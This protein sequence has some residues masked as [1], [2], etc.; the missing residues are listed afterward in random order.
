MPSRWG[1][2]FRLRISG[3]IKGTPGGML[4]GPE[5][6]FEM[7]EGVIRAMRHVHMSPADAEF[8]GVK[9]RRQ[10]EIEN[11]RRRAASLWTKCWCRVDQSF[12]AGSP[13]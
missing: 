5:G 7:T 10:D 1:L 3:D 9:S 12:Q 6:F 2:T 4:M 11:R 8:Y 13:H